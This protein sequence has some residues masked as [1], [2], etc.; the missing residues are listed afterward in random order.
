MLRTELQHHNTRGSTPLSNNNHVTGTYELYH[1]SGCITQE[2]THKPRHDN[3]IFIRK[4]QPPPEDAMF[5]PQQGHKAKGTE[6][7]MRRRS[8]RGIEADQCLLQDRHVH[9]AWVH[10]RAGGRLVN[11]TNM[12]LLAVVAELLRP[13]VLVRC[14]CVY[15]Q[16]HQ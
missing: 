11:T 5:R 7:P 1:S 3:L 2:A 16:Y 14:T 6:P 4:R 8:L 15:D 10:E 12:L 9:G 13:T